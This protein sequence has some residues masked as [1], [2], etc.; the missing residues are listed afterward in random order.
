MNLTL[1]EI[2]DRSTRTET[3]CLE[4]GGN[5]TR[6]GY[7]LYCHGH[8]KGDTKLVHRRSCEL[9]W[10]PIPEGFVVMHHCDN[11]CCVEP[12]HL[13]AATSA[14]NIRDMYRKGRDRNGNRD[15]SRGSKNFNAKLTENQIQE[16]FNLRSKGLSQQS[17]A[18][19]F[20]VRQ[21]SISN[22]LRGCTWKHLKGGN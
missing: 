18:D 13:K 16:I 5:R 3:G 22:V 6:P 15:T 9:F 4:W 10:G 21:T 17:I 14:E 7:P 20:G 19:V 8:K 1:Q 11:P 2:F 12:L